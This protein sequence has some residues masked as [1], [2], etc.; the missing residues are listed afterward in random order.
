M[1]RLVALLAVGAVASFALTTA[2][3]AAPTRLTATVGPGFTIKL[4]KG[5]TPRPG[6]E[7]RKYVITVRDRSREHNFRLRGPVSRMVSTVGWAGTKT[8]TL[9]L[10]AGRYS[11]VCDPH[12][13]KMR[14]A[15]ASGDHG[16]E[17]GPC[18]GPGLRHPSRA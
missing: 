10:K 12:A 2:G 11:Y 15:S 17:P 6:A 9:T 14:A 5:S 13:D 18:G 7:A 4:K 16:R 1:T 8:V 3:T